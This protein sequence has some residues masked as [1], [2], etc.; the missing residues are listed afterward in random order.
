MSG[1]WFRFY[2][3]ALDD[4]K[5][6]RLPP[7]LFK[8]WVNLLCVASRNNG[9]VTCNVTDISFML[10]TT[11]DTAREQIAAL[12]EAGL[13]DEIEGGW[14]PHN[15][16]GRQFSSDSSAERVKRHREKQRNGDVTLHEPLQKRPD[17][18]Y[19]NV[20]EQNRADTEQ[21]RAEVE[22]ARSRAPTAT[23]LP[24]GWEPDPDLLAWAATAE[25]GVDAKR[26]AEKFRDYWR[27]ASGANARK[28]DWA[29]AW[30]TWIRR[31]AEIQSVRPPPPR[32][33][34]RDGPPRSSGGGMASISEAGEAFLERV[35]AEARA[36]QKQAGAAG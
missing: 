25:P 22:G 18:R 7:E 27:A 1:R 26:E 19:S 30:R 17:D 23:R 14:T 8:A 2:D 12:V 5:V 9:N 10:R 11:G 4:P 35:A 15:W 16:H 24:D 33:Q 36:R 20:P 6:Q 29:A 21:N 32:A 34:A 3:G 13:L 28:R 31:A